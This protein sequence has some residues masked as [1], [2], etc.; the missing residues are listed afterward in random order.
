[1]EEEE[2]E[3]K[4]NSVFDLDMQKIKEEKARGGNV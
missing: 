3:L 1:M 4:D 2:K